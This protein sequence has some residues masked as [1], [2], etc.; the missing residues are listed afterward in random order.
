MS[1]TCKTCS[2]W[3]ADIPTSNQ[4]V[5]PKGLTSNLK[6]AKKRPD[7]YSAA[8]RRFTVQACSAVA[9]NIMI[10]NGSNRSWR[11][12]KIF[13]SS[14]IIDKIRKCC[15]W[16]GEKSYSWPGYFRSKQAKHMAGKPGFQHLDHA[17]PR[18]RHQILKKVA[19]LITYF[20]CVFCQILIH[21]RT[22]KITCHFTII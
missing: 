7:W 6:T 2:S 22:W 8:E 17:L 13:A 9:A 20:C 16:E 15:S 12:D 10:K 14:T 19:W 1:A 21:V 18:Q 11:P 5:K 3:P 4:W